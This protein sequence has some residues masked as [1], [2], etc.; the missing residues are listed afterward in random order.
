[1][2]RR[3]PCLTPCFGFDNPISRTPSARR[4]RRVDRR[5]VS[6]TVAPRR[7]RPRWR[8]A[9]G[10]APPFACPQTP[11]IRCVGA[12]ILSHRAGAPAF[13][14]ATH[15]ILPAPVA[16]DPHE[17]RRERPDAPH[18]RRPAYRNQNRQQRV[19]VRKSGK[20]KLAVA[21]FTE[22]GPGSACIARRFYP[23][24]VCQALTALRVMSGDGKPSLTGSPALPSG[25]H[26]P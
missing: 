15:A 12:A 25:Q 21:M 5:Q 24:R 4:C 6:S 7:A 2:H 14:P 13:R 22:R 3:R 20:P 1:M 8:A 26:L 11:K 9:Q 10:I 23:Q 17:P 19:S 18:G 16:G